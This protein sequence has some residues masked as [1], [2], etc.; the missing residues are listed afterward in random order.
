MCGD[1]DERR[2]KGWTWFVQRGRIVVVRYPR[3]PCLPSELPAL[4]AAPPPSPTT[5]ISQTCHVTPSPALQDSQG[6]STVDVA[7]KNEKKKTTLI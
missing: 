6:K 3:A 1:L 4:G 2:E 7:G 5:M